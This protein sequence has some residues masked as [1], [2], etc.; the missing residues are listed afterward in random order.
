MRYATVMYRE[1]W[2]KRLYLPNG[3]SV[4]IQEQ[5]EP[6]Y[7]GDSVFVKDSHGRKWYVTLLREPIL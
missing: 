5:D 2:V 3:G 6:L 7:L 1:A 4:K